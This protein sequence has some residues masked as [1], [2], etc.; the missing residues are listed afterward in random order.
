MWD[1]IVSVPDH[2]LFFYLA[3]DSNLCIPIQ[4]PINCGIYTG[5]CLSPERSGIIGKSRDS[6]DNCSLRFL[7]F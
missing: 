2:C 7:S 4:F 3:K 6:N 5:K 1:L